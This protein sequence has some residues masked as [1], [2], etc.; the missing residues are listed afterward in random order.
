MP[1]ICWQVV[2]RRVMLPLMIDLTD[3]PVLVAGAGSVGLRRALKLAGA[4][5]RVRLQ[6]RTIDPQTRKRC[7]SAGIDCVEGPVSL[8][9]L[10]GMRLIVAA[11]SDKDLNE[12]IV[13]E[14]NRL[15]ILVSSATPQGDENVS[16]PAQIKRGDFVV[17]VSTGG[18]SPALSKRIRQELESRF[19]ED[20][21]ERLKLLS[22]LRA[23]E[24]EEARAEDRKTDSDFLREIASLP[25]E[26]LR[27]TALDQE[28]TRAA[29]ARKGANKMKTIRVGTRGSRLALAQ[30][31]AYIKKL[32]E[33]CPGLEVETEVIRTTGDR[34]QTQALSEIGGKGLFTKE[35]EEALLD[36][37]ID[38]AVHSMKDMPAELPEGL[39]FA[40]SPH[41]APHKD[42]LV[43]RADEKAE[44]IEDFLAPGKVV[45][46]GSLRRSC[47]I[48]EKYPGVEI[49]GIRG[50]IDTR[51]RK[52]LAGDY[53][54]VVLAE[55]GLSRL[56]LGPQS[57][58][59]RILRMSDD[60]VPAP[61]QGILAIEVRD[62]DEEILELC[63]AVADPQAVIQAQAERAFLEA[64]DGS[65]HLPIGAYAEVLENGKL[66]LTGLYG[67][68]TGFHL[69]QTME[70]TREEAREL[71]RTLA[72][73]MRK[74]Y[75]AKSARARE[76]SEN[77][78]KG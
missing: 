51:I 61:A 41:R 65:C 52:M 20:F 44:T 9:D 12:E 15:G 77:K 14:A 72:E 43:V 30:T 75:E 4:G 19:P 45:G 24:L 26:A 67:D 1:S 23:E 63:Q 66:K 8:S 17:S 10:A 50:N 25:I 37:R 21:D 47:Q 74:A 7:E 22:A 28:N 5:A 54:A 68:E 69:K 73:S 33:A 60:F 78:E 62:G 18:A 2:M 3:W 71:G 42:V 11:T 29:G 27:A 48:G 64:L 39:I 32:Q 70:G 35:I 57:L 13:R 59:I 53:D 56:D 76:N 38:L 36:R 58:P 55:A 34:N 49:R 6:S 16:F 40:P 46:T 31:Q